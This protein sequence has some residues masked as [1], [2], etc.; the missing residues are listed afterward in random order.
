MFDKQKIIMLAQKLSKV[1]AKKLG[2]GV[3]V[4]HQTNYID[5]MQRKFS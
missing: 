4:Q 1:T 3:T 5:K 2:N